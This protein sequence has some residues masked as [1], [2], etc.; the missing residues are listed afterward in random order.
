ME[1]SAEGCSPSSSRRWDPAV[2]AAAKKG[3]INLLQGGRM[4]WTGKCPGLEGVEGR[5]LPLLSPFPFEEPSPFL[6]LPVSRSPVDTA[7]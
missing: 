6:S 1:E 5:T 3:E 7:I 2:L 4:A